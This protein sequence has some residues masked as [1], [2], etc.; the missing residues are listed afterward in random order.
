MFNRWEVTDIPKAVRYA[1]E[2]PFT[3]PQWRKRSLLEPR[4]NVLYKNEYGELFET[5][6]SLT[7]LDRK[8][9]GVKFALFGSFDILFDH[10]LSL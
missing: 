4:Y 1:S 3:F 9:D 6:F 8:Y 7:T 2:N 10:L 5:I